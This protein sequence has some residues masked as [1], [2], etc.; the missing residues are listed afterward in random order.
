MD[1]DRRREVGLFRYALI[2][3]A[4]DASLSKAER[5]RLVRALAEQEHLGPEGRVVRVARGTLDEWIRAYRR[6]GFEALV[7]RPR[8]VLPRTSAEVLELAFELKREQ[9]AWTAAQ[10]HQIMLQAGGP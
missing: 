7:P 4:A 6:G 2:R 3:D 8:R 1:E 5:G 9:P 10:V